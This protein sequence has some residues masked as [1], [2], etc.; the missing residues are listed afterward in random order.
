MARPKANQPGPS[1]KERLEQAFWDSLHELSYDSLTVS[2]ISKRARVNHNTF[3]YY[4]ENIDDM[5]E[6]AFKND[7]QDDALFLMLLIF[8]QA[9]KALLENLDIVFSNPLIR[10][11]LQMVNDTEKLWQEVLSKRFTKI[12][13][14]LTNGSTYLIDLFKSSIIQ[15]WANY[16][17]IDTSRIDLLSSLQIEFLL[18]GVIGVYRSLDPGT[19]FDQVLSHINMLIKTPL[20]IAIIETITGIF[21]TYSNTKQEAV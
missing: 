17:A 16:F 8:N 9:D 18:N 6:Q 5:A 3:Y 11:R 19:T 12:Y 10:E 20:G 4:Y 1:A 2:G 15:L 21:N 14:F 13:A 7:L